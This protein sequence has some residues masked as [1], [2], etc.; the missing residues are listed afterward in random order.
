MNPPNQTSEQS[1][2]GI[3][4][5]DL[6]Q[7][8][9]DSET[10]DCLINDLL[11]IAR[12]TEVQIKQTATQYTPKRLWDLSEAVGLLRSGQIR[13]MQVRYDYDG[14]SWCDTLLCRADKC[15]LIRIIQ[16]DLS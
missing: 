13:G 5:P 1:S 3:T 14:R 6:N 9:L 2:R 7:A 15:Q 4:L 11:S 16:P 12:I 8:L 10:L